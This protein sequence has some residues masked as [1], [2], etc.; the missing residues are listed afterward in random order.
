MNVM[1]QASKTKVPQHDEE[2]LEYLNV[3]R[4]NICEAYT[5]ILQGLKSEKPDI[6]LPYVSQVLEFIHMVAQDQNMDEPVCRA[7]V[8][9][10]GDLANV[11][12]KKAASLTGN[13]YITQMVANATQSSDEQTQEAGRWAMAQLQMVAQG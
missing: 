13:Q 5:G 10:I 9:V 6:F 7:C 3:L 4:E 11:F 2:M 8:G 1:D 12:G